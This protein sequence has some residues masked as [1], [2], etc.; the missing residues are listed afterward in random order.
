MDIDLKIASRI[1]N[2]IDVLPM[3]E[4]IKKANLPNY[5]PGVITWQDITLPVVNLQRIN[6]KVESEVTEE[7]CIIVLE[8]LLD[9]EF[10]K[11]GVLV[12]STKEISSLKTELIY[13]PSDFM[14]SCKLVYFVQSNSFKDEYNPFCF[15]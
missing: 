6:G 12:N 5:F 10:M 3:Q 1:N 11:V 2:V 9:D 14:N 15:G 13:L 4:I 8:L 7:T